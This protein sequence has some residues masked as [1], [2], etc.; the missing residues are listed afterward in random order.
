[1]PG[2]FLVADEFRRLL[3]EFS[4]GIALDRVPDAASTN[5]SAEFDPL[6]LRP[7]ADVTAGIEQLLGV[8][9]DVPIAWRFGEYLAT[10]TNDLL[11]VRALSSKD[12]GEAL[13]VALQ[14]QSV[15][16]NVRTISHRSRSGGELI[17]VHHGE[18]TQDHI[19]RFIFQ[20][21]VSSKLAL[22]FQEYSDSNRQHQ[23][24]HRAA[25]FGS[26]M[27]KFDREMDFIDIEYRDCEL[28][29]GFSR[30]VLNYRLADRDGRLV[31]A[32]D[33]E[34]RRKTSEVPVTERWKDRIKYYIRSKHLA[35]VSLDEICGT[36]R[37]AAAH[38][39]P[40]AP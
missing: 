1:M 10:N 6:R 8:A 32:L 14:N 35:D 21:I 24:D 13:G 3:R 23:V 39:R 19:P 17:A 38:A 16:T 2:N 18:G 26:L 11:T 27:Q 31:A 12:I 28:M 29:F 34:L 36:F 33:C 20:S 30:D 9:T 4:A 25:C 22:F 15:L 40:D 37:S 5:N 7:I